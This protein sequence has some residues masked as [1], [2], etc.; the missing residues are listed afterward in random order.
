MDIKKEIIRL[1]EE[2]NAI[3]VAHLYQDGEIQDIADMV[4]DSFELSRYCAATDK[5]VIVFCGVHFMAESAKILSP[6]K[7]V[8]LPV[9]DAGCPMADMANVEDL[10]KLKAKYPEAAVVCYVN[11]T[12][13]IKADVISAA[14]RRSLKK[15]CIHCRTSRFSF[16]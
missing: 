4:G 15:L 14:P 6:Q 8:L 3:I 7:T 12:A 5:D 9:L 1:K 10:K 16:A 11:T 13:A 2:R